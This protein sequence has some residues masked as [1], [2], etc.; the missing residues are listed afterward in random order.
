MHQQLVGYKAEEKKYL[1]VRERKKVEYHWYSTLVVDV[2]LLS[3]FRVLNMKDTGS[4]ETEVITWRHEPE[5]QSLYSQPR[6]N[7]KSD[8]SLFFFYLNT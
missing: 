6:R 8:V 2:M 4:A 7:M 5:D 1:G 3:P